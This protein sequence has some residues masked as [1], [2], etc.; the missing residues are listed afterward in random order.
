MIAMVTLRFEL[1]ILVVIARNLFYG[2]TYHLVYYSSKS[3]VK[4]GGIIHGARSS[5]SF[6]IDWSGSVTFN[7]ENEN[8]QEQICSGFIE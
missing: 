3:F 6:A 2:Y 1:V 4:E 5:P 7:L 8:D